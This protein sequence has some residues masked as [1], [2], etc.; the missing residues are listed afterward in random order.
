MKQRAIL[1]LAGMLL[2]A[3]ASQLS[4][5]VPSAYASVE[6][7]L[8]DAIVSRVLHLA[9][10]EFGVDDAQMVAQYNAGQVHIDDLG[11]I[12]GGHRYG[13]TYNA[14]YVIVADLVPN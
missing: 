9:S 4:A 10:A 11:P 14:D 5:S 2:A 13:V 7:T 6:E 12:R 3:P 1:L 8:S